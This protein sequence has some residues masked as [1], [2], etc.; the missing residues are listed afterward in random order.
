MKHSDYEAAENDRLR[1]QVAVLR[2]RLAWTT[3]VT[4]PQY[5]EVGEILY[6]HVPP[7]RVRRYTAAEWERKLEDELAW[8]YYDDDMWLYRNVWHQG[9]LVRWRAWDE[10][11]ARRLP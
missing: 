8:A 10:V 2:E 6:E 7:G 5:A 1:R 11:E 4:V 3:A 9:L